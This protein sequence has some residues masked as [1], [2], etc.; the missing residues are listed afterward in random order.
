MVD[1]YPDSEWALP[2][3]YKVALVTAKGFPGADYDDTGLKDA[4][5]QMEEFLKKHPDAQIS[6]EASEQLKSLR[7]KEAEKEFEIAQFYEKQRKY[8]AAAY[9]Y[10]Q[11]ANKYADTQIAKEAQQKAQELAGKENM[12]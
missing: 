11:L 5:K 8:R 9:Y 10:S 6:P 4:A 2:S 1:N 3:K 7:D 12:R